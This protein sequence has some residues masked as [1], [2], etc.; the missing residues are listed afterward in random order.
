MKEYTDILERMKDF[1]KSE[2]KLSHSDIVK[3]NKIS[4]E[5]GNR[6]IPV[7]NLIPNKNFP[8]NKDDQ[9]N[10]GSSEETLKQAAQDT[11][12]QSFPEGPDREMAKE[13]F[14]QQES[15]DSAD[16][17]RGERAQ[18][19]IHEGIKKRNAR[20][21]YDAKEQNNIY[22][23]KYPHA[24]AAD[25]YEYLNKKEKNNTSTPVEQQHLKNNI[26]GSDNNK[27]QTEIRTEKTSTSEII[28][29]K[30]INT[31]KDQIDSV[32]KRLD[33]IGDNQTNNKDKEIL[34]K[35]RS[36]LEKKLETLGAL[37]DQT[38]QNESRI[39]N[40]LSQDSSDL[41]TV[42]NLKK[43]NTGFI[44]VTE[45]V[46]SQNV[47][48]KSE[49]RKDQ[50]ATDDALDAIKNI[51]IKK[52]PVSLEKKVTILEQKL[53]EQEKKASPF[54]KKMG[55][56][57][58][59]LSKLKEGKN[60]KTW[61]GKLVELQ[62]KGGKYEKLGKKVLLGAGIAAVVG[63]IGGV[64]GAG[65]GAMMATQRILASAAAGAGASFLHKKITQKE[66]EKDLSRY[67]GLRNEELTNKK[68]QLENL[69]VRL[70]GDEFKKLRSLRQENKGSDKK[71]Q[72]LQ[73][74]EDRYEKFNQQRKTRFS[75]T[76]KNYHELIHRRELKNDKNNKLWAA[77]AGLVTG[78]GLRYGEDILGLI[79]SDESISVNQ[80]TT[81]IMTE[82]VQETPESKLIIP[83]PEKIES[84]ISADAFI[85]KG[86]GITHALKRQ[87]EDNPDIAKKLGIEGKATGSD[88]ARIAK[89]FGYIKDDGSD[90]RVF[91]GKGA[92]YELT[93]DDAGK[94]IMKE[95]FGG[96]IEGD[97]YVGGT[98]KEI[99]TR[100]TN[101]E[102]SHH[103]GIGKG[104]GEYEYLPNQKSQSISS[105]TYKGINPNTQLSELSEN[106]DIQAT[107][108]VN[109]PQIFQKYP[110]SLGGTG[111]QVDGR[112]GSKYGHMITDRYT[113]ELFHSKGIHLN[114]DTFWDLGYR[115]EENGKFI[116][117]N[118][119][120]KL[121]SWKDVY[122]QTDFKALELEHPELF[123]KNAGF[124]LNTA[125]ILNNAPESVGLNPNNAAMI[126]NGPTRE[127]FT[128]S[129][130]HF[131]VIHDEQGNIHIQSDS[132]FRFRGKMEV[133]DFRNREVRLLEKNKFKVIEGVPLR[134]QS[135]VPE[136]M[137]TAVVKLKNGQYAF[138]ASAGSF[139]DLSNPG[140]AEE[141]LGS[142]MRKLGMPNHSEHS[143]ANPTPQKGLS[144]RDVYTSRAFTPISEE[145][146]RYIGKIYS[147]INRYTGVN[148][149]K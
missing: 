61:Y 70:T 8:K 38:Q 98:S 71:T 69:N 68:S 99:H 25:G 18:E 46:S 31:L 103:E 111:M 39:E 134:T 5:L 47:E 34:E 12:I 123:S 22:A 49:K 29:N 89:E 11:I 21:Y 82:S 131:E 9:V 55:L 124:N 146:A 14:D 147:E 67:K 24:Y 32:S 136:L 105:D 95:H 53:A 84:P 66:V 26:E 97:T 149:P 122:E 120:D 6:K 45:Q 140:L 76:K 142:A 27:I 36:Y 17:L 33:A 143:I 126:D 4:R 114:Q 132:E 88:L 141:R 80:E 65:I 16:I 23:D 92:V 48:S 1:K 52:N 96:R 110:N 40:E 137:G 57:G 62:N 51:V 15:K 19:R 104:T 133:D 109:N 43:I 121:Y 7:N 50:S 90:V 35:E 118:T 144:G 93:L 129:T 112:F 108:T 60:G 41:E 10:L 102:G 135:N 113:V 91:M 83:T 117:E 13:Y 106:I 145:Q 30:S 77:G 130:G 139:T 79:N 28:R 107:N 75:E 74:L 119:G 42:E 20:S 87:L 56:F 125:P 3:H 63:G 81:P 54:M 72:E 58:R 115:P 148:N 44:K 128:Q 94:P 64:A 101:F 116:N 100:G 78:L 85:N 37:G 2:K 127:A 86:E 59:H 138:A 73:D